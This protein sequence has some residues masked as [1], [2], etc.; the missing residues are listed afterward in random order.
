MRGYMPIFMFDDVGVNGDS[1][2]TGLPIL[3]SF[4]LRIFPNNIR[5]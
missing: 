3:V 5:G 1:V 2:L 4:V